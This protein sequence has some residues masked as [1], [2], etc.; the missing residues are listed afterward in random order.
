MVGNV[1][2]LDAICSTWF[3]TQNLY[4]HMINFLPV[5]S[6]TPLRP[7]VPV[8][9]GYYEKWK[10]AEVISLRDSG[11]VVVKYEGESRLMERSRQK[12]LA[13]DPKVLAKAKAN[14]D[15][16]TPSVQVLPG[17][18][19]PIPDGAIPLADD[20]ELHPGTP[21]LLDY[22]DKKWHKVFVVSDSFG[23]IKIRYE[24]YGANWDKSFPR[25]K[26]LIEKATLKKLS[27]P[28]LVENFQR[29]L[30][31]ETKSGRS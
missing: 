6:K 13:I 15:K 24:G 11:S 23:E 7:G 21:L 14:P 3:G 4:V 31:G 19:Q 12:W 27:N 18:L 17:G 5:T 30:Q 9:A 20:I 28:E 10:N 25:T 2:M 29:N 26:L 16:F 22:H 8:K 1:G